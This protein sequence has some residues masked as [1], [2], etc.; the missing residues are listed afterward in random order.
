MSN[1]IYYESLGWQGLLVEPGDAYF[2]I[3]TKK[4]KAWVFHG[5]ISPSKGS[6]QLH[7][8]DDG[9]F[10]R[11]NGTS[12]REVQAEPLEKLI[13]A[14][15]SDRRTVD[16]WSLDI[17]GGECK[18]LESTDFQK[19]QVGILM[20]EMNKGRE[21][22]NCIHSLMER[23]GFQDIGRTQLDH[24]FINPQYMQERGLSLPEHIDGMYAYSN[25]ILLDWP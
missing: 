13:R 4:R 6:M 12:S 1:T 17:E 2:K 16:F 10:G 18:V 11:E 14:I 21:H 19:L 24:V 9:V 15:D 20:I 3:A 5:A 22:I 23:N 8:T 25:R 7:F